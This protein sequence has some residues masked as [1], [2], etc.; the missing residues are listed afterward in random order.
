VSYI[1]CHVIHVCCVVL[2]CVVLCCVVDVC[3]ILSSLCFEHFLLWNSFLF[4]TPPHI[5]PSIILCL[6]F[7]VK[8]HKPVVEIKQVFIYIVPWCCLLVFVLL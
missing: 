5:S 7:P 1:L 4:L 3:G 6:L 2:C 8:Q